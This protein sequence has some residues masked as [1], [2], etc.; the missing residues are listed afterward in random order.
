MHCEYTYVVIASVNK[1][2]WV[3][4]SSSAWN[5]ETQTTQTELWLKQQSIY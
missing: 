5:M 2:D 3:A 1:I 4:F